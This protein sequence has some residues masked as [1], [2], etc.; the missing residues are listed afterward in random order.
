MTETFDII[1]QAYPDVALARSGVFQWDQAFLEGWEEAVDEDHAG[2][3][4]TNTN[5]VTCVCKVLNS[6]CQ[7]SIHLVAQMLTLPK[8]VVHDI[9]TVHLNMHKV[10][11]KMVQKVLTNNQKLW[12]LEVCQENLNI[13]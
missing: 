3:H 8:S 12:Q 13:C 5:N 9:V 11:A 7:L 4:S 2:R 1:K 10:C 6:D